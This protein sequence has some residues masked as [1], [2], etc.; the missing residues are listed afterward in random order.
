M[1]RFTL[2][3]E[4][5]CSPETFW[6]KVNFD[7]EMNQ[8][9]FLEALG[10]PKYELLELRESDTEIFRRVV[11]APKIDLPGA[12]RKLVGSNFHYNE[13]M[14]YDRKTGI[15]TFKTIPSTLAEKFL[16]EGTMRME[17][18][19][20]NRCRRTT[21]FR[22]EAKIPLLGGTIENITEKTVRDGYDKGA[23][24]MNKWIREKGLDK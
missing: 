6:N 8:K 2:V 24:F 17:A 9:M 10:F 14:R 16:S 12:I 21:D 22:V 1:G 19:G 5:E 3:H 13:E 11:T 15:A 4:F 20:P 23:V 7:K 18:L